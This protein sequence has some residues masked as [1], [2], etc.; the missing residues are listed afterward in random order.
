MDQFEARLRFLT[1]LQHLNTKYD[2][3]PPNAIK[4]LIKHSQYEEDLYSCIQE[5]L[6]QAKDLKHRL[7]LFYFIE[8]LCI[9]TAP[10]SSPIVVSSATSREA[11]TSLDAD[12]D[13][14]LPTSNVAA[15]TGASNGGAVAGRPGTKPG[16]GKSDVSTRVST[17]DAGGAVTR[18]QSTSYHSWII[19]DLYK[20]VGHVVPVPS[21]DANNNELLD[22][23]VNIQQVR[24]ALQTFLKKQ[25][26]S[27]T[28]FQE[29]NDLLKTRE[30][31]M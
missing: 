25:F 27:A 30:E 19:Q 3:T 26:I 7:S 9:D 14:S 15:A 31:R 24:F 18:P 6:D 20:I 2:A 28:T 22:T 12:L 1:I 4:F 21:E 8:S 13:T 16:Q 10:D 23:N 11:S 17:N 29:L 5:T